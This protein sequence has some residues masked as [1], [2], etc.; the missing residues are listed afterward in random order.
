MTS[1]ESLHEDGYA[2]LR[3][4]V[5]VHQLDALRAAFDSGFIPAEQWPVQRGP[6]WRHSLLDL[7]GN[8]H[9]VCRLPLLL[10]TV[11]ELIGETFFLAQVEGREPLAGGGHQALHR[12]LSS[13]RPGDTVIAIAYF[14]DY[15]AD[16]GATRIVPRSHRP[17]GAPFDASDDERSEQISGCA[18]DILVFDADLLHAACLNKTGARRR[19]A[20][21]TYFAAPLYETHLRTAK[22][23]SVRMDTSDRFDQFGRVV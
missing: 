19:S 1:H 14:D 9:N 10:A 21:F 6:D 2:L 18:G 22:L 4:A 5:A 20:L 15:G 3:G 12:D 16:N 8:V 13:H 23:R 17:H 7:D 11:G